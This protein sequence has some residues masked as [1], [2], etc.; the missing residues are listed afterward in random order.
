MQRMTDMRVQRNSGIIAL[1]TCS[2]VFDREG[3]E[4]VQDTARLYHR[5]IVLDLINY[6]GFN[7]RCLED[8]YARGKRGMITR[9]CRKFD[10]K[11]SELSFESSLVD[12]DTE[13]SQ[14]SSSLC[15]VGRKDNTLCVGERSL[16]SEGIDLDVLN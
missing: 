1:V 11:Y 4:D 7:M 5:G 3:G 13:P 15:Y 12:H 6:R 16:T 8:H 10:A 14:L 9:S 2:L